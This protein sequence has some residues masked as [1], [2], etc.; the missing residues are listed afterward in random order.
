[1]NLLESK[2][3]GKIDDGIRNPTSMKEDKPQRHHKGMEN[4]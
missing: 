2:V 4:P 1:L 3:S